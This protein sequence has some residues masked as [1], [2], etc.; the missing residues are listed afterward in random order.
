MHCWTA[1]WAVQ[2]AA[3]K[4]AVRDWLFW[5]C[6]ALQAPHMEAYEGAVMIADITGFTA[7]TEDL[8]RKGPAGVELLTRCMNH[9]FSL[10]IN[11]VR[12][13]QSVSCFMRA[14]G[15]ARRLLLH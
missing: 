6:A 5:T 14:S 15:K 3:G 4:E 1:A 7:L 8:G 11:T 9:F 10:V 13:R 2:R 12:R